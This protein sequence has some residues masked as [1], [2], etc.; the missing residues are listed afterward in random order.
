MASTAFEGMALWFPVGQGVLDLPS[1]T[2]LS[3][4]SLPLCPVRI[5]TKQDTQKG[6]LDDHEKRIRD[7][8]GDIQ[9]AKGIAIAAGG[10]GGVLG[11][12]GSKLGGH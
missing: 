12:L 1:A 4:S 2:A 9:K 3:C 11:W 7:S 5:E 10:V 8:E 6:I